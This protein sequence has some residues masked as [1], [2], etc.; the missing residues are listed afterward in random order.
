MKISA[1]LKSFRP[2]ADR[3]IHYQRSAQ[4]IKFSLLT[5]LSSFEI[6]FC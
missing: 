6:K 3:Q 4:S 2:I 1:T 5:V